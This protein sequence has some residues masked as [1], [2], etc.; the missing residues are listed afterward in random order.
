M[1][2]GGGAVNHADG[3]VNSELITHKINEH[4][5]QQH[6]LS[7]RTPSIR[8]VGKV[9]SAMLVLMHLLCIFT[10]GHSVLEFKKLTV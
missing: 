1:L 9:A 10:L 7:P 8:G 5:E 6:T 3:T 4:P 2:S